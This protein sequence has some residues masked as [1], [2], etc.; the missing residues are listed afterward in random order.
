MGWNILSN[1]SPD[2][3]ETSIQREC[4]FSEVAKAPK[5][6]YWLLSGDRV[7]CVLT[8]YDKKKKELRL[9]VISEEEGPLYYSCPRAFLDATT[10]MNAAWRKK[11]RT[12]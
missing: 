5:G 8:E 9:K 11:V 3:I 6:V 12:R 1:V 10:V 4:W 2:Q 7:Y